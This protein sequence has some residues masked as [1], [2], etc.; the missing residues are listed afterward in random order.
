MTGAAARR[1]DADLIAVGL[2]D[3]E[4]SVSAAAAVAALRVPDPLARPGSAP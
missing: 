4:P 2:A 1:Y 3:P